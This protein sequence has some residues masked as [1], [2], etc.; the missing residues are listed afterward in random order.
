MVLWSVPQ[1]NSSTEEAITLQ[2]ST[3]PVA[4]HSGFLPISPKTRIFHAKC[5]SKR[6]PTAFLVVVT[7][8]SITLK[9]LGCFT[10]IFAISVANTL[11]ARAR[12]TKNTKNA[13]NEVFS[14]FASKIGL[15]SLK[16]AAKAH[17]E[18]Q[19]GRTNLIK[20]FLIKKYAIEKFF[21]TTL[22]KVDFSGLRGGTFAV[23]FL[24]IQTSQR[25]TVCTVGNVSTCSMFPPNPIPL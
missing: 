7:L 16:T 3:L 6:T 8:C 10:N 25:K 19:S 14:T 20:R 17:T 23:S 11:S 24:N 22:Q 5:V 2:S 12:T 9:V 4:F 18:L 1:T 21:H 15:F 13:K